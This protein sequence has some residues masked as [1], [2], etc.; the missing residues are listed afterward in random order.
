VDDGERAEAGRDWWPI[1]I[2]WAVE[3]RVPARPAAVVR[4]KDATQVA[5]V[6]A[7]CAQHGVPVTPA[8]GRSGVCGGSVPLFGG[9]ALDLTG[10]VGEVQVDATSLI[11]QVPAGV[12]GPALE[13]ALRRT[14][15]TLG[16]WPQ[17]M[18][19]STVGGW[20]ACRGAGQYS[21]R[22]GKIEDM[23]AG[24]EVA[25]ADGTLLRTGG[26]APRSATGPDLTQVFCGSEGVLGVITGVWLRIHPLPAAEDRRAYGFESFAGGLDACR[27]VLRRGATPAVLRLYDPIESARSFGVHDACVLVVLDEADPGLLGATLAV[28]DE[29]CA[30]A[31]RLGDE[32]VA[33]WLA[34]RND[35]S[36]LAPLWR[37]GVV[38][39]TAE[40]AGHWRVLP[41]IVDEA[42]AALRALD[43]TIAASVHQS[44]AYLDGACLYFTFAGRGDDGEAYYVAAWD[45]L[46]A[47]VEQHGA[48]ISHH[49][50][51]GLN[52]GRFAAELPE[53]RVLAA[54]KR[55]L[56]PAGVLN[57]GKL[58]LKSAFGEVRWP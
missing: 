33:H 11:A 13:A 41:G 46:M 53:Q 35:V 20:V 36:A 19:L 55:A 44:H 32:L 7:A 51:I 2:G 21:T 30:A 18:A 40:V 38:V 56:D 10:L 24:L 49:H 34:D 5:E 47:T 25:L 48:A 17:S 1:S 42:L 9:L 37:A 16:H 12:F 45:T 39:D 54:L 6:L 15:H 29:E 28:V 57:P 50:G 22:Y 4:P 26:R 43:G 23:V 8:A 52:R 58:G 3:G 31:R 27:R 14:G